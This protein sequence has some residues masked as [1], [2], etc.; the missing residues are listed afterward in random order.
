[1]EIGR[2]KDSTLGELR[3]LLGSILNVRAQ[4]VTLSQVRVS[5]R[6][7]TSCV[8]VLHSSKDKNTLEQMKLCDGDQLAAETA[9]KKGMKTLAHSVADKQN[10]L[11]SVIVEDRC[12][13]HSSS[14]PHSYPVLA[15]EVAKDTFLSSF[16]AAVLSK[17]HLSSIDGGGRLRLDDDSVGPPLHENQSLDQAGVDQGHRIILEPGLAPTAKQL[18]L[19]CVV[20]RG[21]KE[22]E[23]T[24][25]RSNTVAECC[26]AMVQAAGLEGTQWH[27]RKTNWCGEAAEVLEDESAELHKE[28]LKSGDL[29]LIEEGKLPPKNF[30]RLTISLY[31]PSSPTYQ[32][33]YLTDP[34]LA[35]GLLSWVMDSA[36]VISDGN[37]QGLTP[38]P[39]S[40]YTVD[41]NE[42]PLH[43][44][45]PAHYYPGLPGSLMELDNIEIHRDATVEELKALIVTLPA[46]EN[47]T[48][49]TLGFLRVRELVDGRLGKV[50]KQP[51]QTLRRNKLTSG[52]SVCVTVLDYE[53]KLPATVI[54]FT[55]QARMLGGRHYGPAAEVMYDTSHSTKPSELVKSLTALLDVPYTRLRVAKHKIESFEWIQLQDNYNKEGSKRRG[56]KKTG[57]TTANLKNAPVNLR[58]GDMLGVKDLQYDPEDSDDFS[59][60]ED[61]R[62]RA[63]LA[64]LQEEKRRKRKACDVFEGSTGRTNERRAEVGIKIFVPDYKRKT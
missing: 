16:K 46:L 26:Q 33:S 21:S 37:E 27:L 63:I 61:D 55:V 1:M 38:K 48:I 8:V 13:P 31:T 41:P 34:A 45:S 35:T 19:R 20:S 54:V 11:L 2:A 30:I 43:L 25:D 10:N 59:T 47:V 28:H 32:P 5:E 4:Q 22:W 62:G 53:E 3:A 17:L 50:L 23:V 18:V 49:P 64:A 29:L 52:S 14:D 51:Q 44:Q 24:V 15:M 40:S 12:S 42:V 60:P 57:S 39:D 6:S 7:K 58:D 9:I 36:T 56:K